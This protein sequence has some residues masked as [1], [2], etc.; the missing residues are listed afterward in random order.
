[1]KN[2]MYTIN[3]EEVRVIEKTK[4]GFLGKRVLDDLECEE[5]NE[6]FEQEQQ[7][8]YFESLFT[9][10]PTQKLEEEVKKLTTAKET[11]QAEVAQLKKDESTLKNEIKS[12][13]KY[14]IVGDLLKYLNGNFE[15]AL[16]TEDLEIVNKSKF[17]NT[18]WIRTANIKNKGFGLYLMRNEYHVGSDDRHIKIFDSEYEAIQ[19]AKKILIDRIQKLDPGVYKAQ[20]RLDGMISSI[21]HTFAKHPSV[22]NAYFIKI[23]EI[24]EEEKN[25]KQKAIEKKKK[26]L[27]EL[28]K[29]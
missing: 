17:Y 11:L 6:F 20:K 18:H 7:V 2:T 24:E 9:K 15:V 22:N 23:R 13:G 19:E 16:Y 28:Q 21:R 26:E 29:S 4:N 8:E 3:G 14:P 27:E 12:V 10:A 1:M 5:Y 25:K